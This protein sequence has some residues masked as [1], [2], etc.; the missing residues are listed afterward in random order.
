MRF[1]NT[2]TDERKAFACANFL[3]EQGIE[4]F[5]EPTGSGPQAGYS[6]WVIEEDCSEKAR[7]FLVQFNALTPEE[8]LRYERP[9]VAPPPQV[10]AQGSPNAGKGN[11]AP[12]VNLRWQRSPPRGR[13]GFTYFLIGLCA[14]LFFVSA[15]EESQLIKEEG[16]I[17]LQ[18]GLTPIQ[19]T[20][21]FDLPQCFDETQKLLHE[22]PLNS[23]EEITTLPSEV[24]A[25]FAK[26]EKCPFWRGAFEI[27]FQKLKTGQGSY[28]SAPLFEK[29]RKGEVWRVFTPCLLHRDFLHILFNMSWLFILGRMIEERAGRMRMLFLILI[30]GIISNVTQYLMSGPYFLGFSGVVCGMAAFIWMRQRTSPWEGYPLTKGTILFLAIFVAAMSLLQ[31]VSLGLEYF[32]VGGVMS[33]IANTA[34]IMGGLSGLALARIPIFS[35]NPL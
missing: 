8:V 15:F 19:R 30:I 12:L 9:K 26:A 31:M 24:Q 1:L 2:F 4:T 16:R 27:F 17:A 23:F 20:L 28:S 35:R 13:Y 7:D 29:I 14:F 10:F 33:N 3:R 22:Y 11:A 21:V 18:I 6:L 32:G 25:E 5:Y 34:H